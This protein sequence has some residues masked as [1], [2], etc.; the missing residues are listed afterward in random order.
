VREEPGTVVEPSVETPRAIKPP[1][2]ASVAVLS[3]S[4]I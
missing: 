3:V 1:D 2:K 4:P